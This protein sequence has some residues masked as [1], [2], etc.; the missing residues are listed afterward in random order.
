MEAEA[1]TVD[2]LS[3]AYYPQG[4]WYY[5]RNAASLRTLPRASRDAWV[6]LGLDVIANCHSAVDDQRLQ[7]QFYKNSPFRQCRRDG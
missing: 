3:S 1:L 5:P 7:F 6:L 2:H 4:H